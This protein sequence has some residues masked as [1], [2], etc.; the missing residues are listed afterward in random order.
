[1]S[2]ASEVA[3]NAASRYV[4]CERAPNPTWVMLTCQKIIHFQFQNV[5]FTE[6]GF[7]TN[8]FSFQA[9]G[10]LPLLVLDK[11]AF[12][13]VPKC[14]RLAQHVQTAAV[15]TAAASCFHR[16]SSGFLEKETSASRSFRRG[17]WAC[18]GSCD[19]EH[20]TH[21]R[22]CGG[23]SWS[24][25]R[26]KVWL[27]PSVRPFTC[28]C[29][30]NCAP[31]SKNGGSLKS[32]TS[33]LPETSLSTPLHRNRPSVTTVKP[34]CASSPPPSSSSALPKPRSH[35]HIIFF[36]ASFFKQAQLTQLGWTHQ[37][38]SSLLS[39]LLPLYLFKL[40]Q[41]WHD[42][43]VMF[44]RSQI[45]RRLSILQEE[46]KKSQVF[47]KHHI[48]SGSSSAPLRTFVFWSFYNEKGARAQKRASC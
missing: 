24:S 44:G 45:L 20:R 6:S 40:S 1:M 21:T 9:A 42:V 41:Q 39:L 43:L 26:W 10:F 46:N 48:S 33:R 32:N 25:W 38:N 3:P 5:W 15:F 28:T 22:R 12:S 23:W 27:S 47:S 11:S 2:H 13:N 17:V 37:S 7:K 34:D 29:R 18:P 4:G 30:A 31:K 35:H 8:E 19:R 36:I 16:F 14:L